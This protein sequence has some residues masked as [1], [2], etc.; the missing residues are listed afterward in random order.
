MGIMKNKKAGV[1]EATGVTA[2]RIIMWILLGALLIWALFW[3]SNFG[4]YLIK[5]GKSYLK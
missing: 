1:G 4:T 2:G 5:L 3:Y